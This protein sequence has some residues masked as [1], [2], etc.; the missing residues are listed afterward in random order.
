M[1]PRRQRTVRVT[2]NG[3]VYER[4]V[5]TRKTLADFLR[6]DLR[7]TGTHVG[8]EHG[9]CGACTVILN[10]HPV[11]SCLLLAVQVNDSQVETVEGMAAPDGALHPLQQAFQHHHA[12]QYGF[13]TPGF[14]LTLKVALQENR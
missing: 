3:Q 12:L 1:N 4:D 9:V 2:V 14:L 5:P 7:L 11:R 13:C 10:D 8:C 6:Q